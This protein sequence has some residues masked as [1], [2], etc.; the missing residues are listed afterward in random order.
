MTITEEQSQ[1]NREALLGVFVQSS[2]DIQSSFEE[3]GDDFTPVLVL[4]DAT[5]G[6][7]VLGFDPQFLDSVAAKDLWKEAMTKAVIEF[8]A[9][10]ALITSS[11]WLRDPDDNSIVGEALLATIV[12]P[13][14]S[15]TYTRDIIR[16]EG[17][18]PRLEDPKEMDRVESSL[19][20]ALAKGI[21]IVVDGTHTNSEE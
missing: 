21:F 6:S 9:V 19:V 4:L 5:S 20:Q 12:T 8:G 10:S 18:L 7:K 2:D 16:E 13:H 17:Q 1:R 11:T 15:W 14:G 3:E